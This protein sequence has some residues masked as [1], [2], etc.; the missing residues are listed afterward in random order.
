KRSLAT[1]PTA[2]TRPLVLTRS[3][4]ATAAAATRPTVQ[5]R[6][7]ATSTAASTRPPVLMRL[8]ATAPATTTRPTEDLHLLAIPPAPITRPTALKRSKKAPAATT[9]P[10]VFRPDSISPWAIAIYTSAT[11]VF[12][13]SRTPSASATLHNTLKPLSPVSLG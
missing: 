4:A 7:L 9:S 13:L 2:T 1:T 6:S 11:T 5:I 12:L 8:I 3:L 10:W